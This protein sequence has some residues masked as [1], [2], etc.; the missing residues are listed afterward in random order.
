MAEGFF[1]VAHEADA[2]IRVQTPIL[3]Q[4]LEDAQVAE[5]DSLCRFVLLEELEIVNI[6]LLVARVAKEGRKL[7]RLGLVRLEK[8]LVKA[9]LLQL[10]HE[11]RFL[12]QV[13][14]NALLQD[15]IDEAK[16]FDII[17]SHLT[18]AHVREQGQH[19]YYCLVVEPLVE[20]VPFVHLLK[21]ERIARAK[22][23]RRLRRESHRAHPVHEARIQKH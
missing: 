10:L 17:C 9:M 15:S 22:V 16:N 4:P 19:G 13:L 7:G 14:R 3:P 20:D 1:L 18:E 11:E 2:L 5:P 8:R 21:L 6:E 23:P 12:L